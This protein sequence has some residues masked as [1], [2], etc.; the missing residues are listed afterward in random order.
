MRGF[1]EL[2]PGLELGGAVRLVQKLGEGGM[3]SVWVADHLALRTQVAVKFLAPHMAQD[4]GAAARFRREATA[5]ARVKSPHIVQIFDHGMSEDFGPYIVMELLDGE[6]V[7]AF[8]SRQGQLSPRVTA[9]IIGQLCKAL[10]KAHQ[11]GI[12]HRDIKPD[13][14]FL[15]DSAREIFVKVLDFGI[16]KSLNDELH[17]TSTG[18][19]MGT[20]HYMSPEQM[21][22]SKHV[23][24]RADLWAV[25]VLAYHCVT[26]SVPFDG[27]TFG[28]IAIAISHGS[29]APPHQ[30]RGVGSPALDA[31]FVRALAREPQDRFQ[32]A[33]ELAEAFALAVSAHSGSQALLGAPVSDS[34][35][36][37]T[38]TLDSSP[39]RT[40]A[41]F[42][43]VASTTSRARHSKAVAIG[44][45][46]AGVLGLATLV[47]L[48]SWTGRATEAPELERAQATA[49]PALTASA[50]PVLGTSGASAPASPAV[51]E[52]P[53]S[54]P[55]HQPA[56]ARAPSPPSPAKPKP[57]PKP[58][59]VEP[60]TRPDR[61]DRGF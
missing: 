13:N 29:F 60:T 21:L 61:P 27:E 36:S 43:G 20:P 1:L 58:P 6:T 55:A 28:A 38:V 42:T 39:A 26:G 9:E 2:A 19:M 49:T 50:I 4:V 25:A 44:A 41:T 23:D 54:E 37:A 17:M 14:V 3:G 52:A 24:F 33:V 53:K 7:S 22:S 12:V 8:V 57:K 15:I 45:A 10:G 18:T 34:A 59:A 32:S 40:A 31:W 11:L 35:R 47:A 5:A 46:A 16:A 48:L 51:I 30:L 56:A